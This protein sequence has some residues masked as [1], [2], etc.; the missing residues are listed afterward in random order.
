VLLGQPLGVPFPIQL[1]PAVLCL[2]IHLLLLLSSLP[3][4]FVHRMARLPRRLLRCGVQCGVV[5]LLDMLEGVL[6]VLL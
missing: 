3:I 1:V 5:R 2:M 4:G 6:I